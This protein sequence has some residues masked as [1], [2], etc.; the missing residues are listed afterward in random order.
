MSVLDVITTVAGGVFSG[1]AT[2][3]IGIGLQRFFDYKQKKLD[4]ET[5]KENLASAERIRQA[6]LA[7]DERLALAK[8]QIVDR[9]ARAEEYL[10]EMD[11]ASRES[12]AASREMLARL[13]SDKATYL[14]PEAQKKSRT[15]TLMMGFVDFCRG[16]FRPAAAMYLLGLCTAMWIW[17]QDLAV[18]M[19]VAMTAAQ[20]HELMVQLLATVL[21]CQTTAMVW[22]YGSRPAQDKKQK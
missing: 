2:G 1:G 8:V 21:Y 16:I 18:R 13:A 11:F 4:L 9:E 6:E 10:A 7:S 15:V 12:E 20:I 14:D 17:L 22:Y 3:L 19:G 5:L